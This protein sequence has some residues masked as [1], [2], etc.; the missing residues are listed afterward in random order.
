[1]V[2]RIYV[3]KKPGFDVEAQQLAHELRS[4]LG[5]TSLDG[6]APGEP[7]RRGG[8]LAGAVRSVRAH[9]VQRAP[10]RCRLGRAAPGRRR[11]GV[12]RGVPAR[13][14]RPARGLGKRVHPAD[15]PGRAPRGAH[16]RRCTCCPARCPIEDVEAIKHYVINPVEAREATLEQRDTLAHG[17]APSPSRS[18]CSRASL[19]LDDA[20][21]A[22]FIADREPGHGRGRPR[23]SASS[24]SRAKA[25]D[26]TITEIKMIDTYWSDHCR[27]TTF[28]TEIDR[29]GHR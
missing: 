25:V 29:R 20:G 17:T 16:A 15:Q 4:I 28:G 5:I 2:S 24:T 27:H 6:F 14:V 19:D 3:E 10:G 11:A 21:L 1:M 12:R 13:P 9:R 7:L 22:Q 23:R 18:R 26:P 8:H